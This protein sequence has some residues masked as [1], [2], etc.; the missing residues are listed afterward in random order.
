[1]ASDLHQ[2]A[3]S[4]AYTETDGFVSD[5]KQA[6]SGNRKYLT[7]R[8]LTRVGVDAVYFG[9]ETPLVYFRALDRTTFD[10]REI[11]ELHRRVWNDA[12]VPVLIV[13]TRRELRVYDACALPHVEDESA[14]PD[15]RL[16]VALE[17]T[18]QALADHR[19]RPFTRHQIE[20]GATWATYATRF[21]NE[22]RCDR[23]LLKNLEVTRDRLLDAD[24]PAEVVHELLPRIILILYLEHR[25]VLTSKFYGEF[26]SGAERLVDVLVSPSRT[27]RMFDALAEH[28]NGDLLPVGSE[29][30]RR[31]KA[32]HLDLLG[33]LL[34]GTERFDTGQRAF[35]PL[36]DFNVIPTELISSIYEMFLRSD[37]GTDAKGLH[38]TPP[39]L[40]EML[41]NEVLPW[42]DAKPS[43]DWRP[44]RIVDPACGSGIFLVEAYRRIVETVRLQRDLHDKVPVDVLRE[45]LSSCIFGVDEVKASVNVAACSLYLAMLDYIQPKAI[46]AQVRF[47]TL[48][49][50]P[51]G[52]R[53]NLIASDAFEPGAFEKHET[54]DLI[55]G[56]PPWKRN[57]LPE[58]AA[59][60]CRDRER[61]AAREIAHAFLW[62][63]T[64]LAGTSGKVAMFATSKWLF[65]REGPD[66]DFREAFFAQNRVDMV[67]NFSALRRSLF[68]A[69]TGP[70]SAVIFSPRSA[71]E[72]EVSNEILYGAPQAR[73]AGPIASALLTDAS[74]WKFVPSAYATAPAIWKVLTRGTWRDYQLYSKLRGHGPT[75]RQFIKERSGWSKGN[76]F[77]PFDPARNKAATNTFKDERL[78]RMPHIVAGKLAPYVVAPNAIQPRL[79][80]N[81][82]F[83]RR[84]HEA[85]YGAKPKVLVKEG[86]SNGKFCA[87]FFDRECTFTETI[88]GITGPE[89]DRHLLQ[90]LAVYLNSAVAT[91]FTFLNST[92][93]GIEREKVNAVEWLELPSD[94][95]ANET[96]AREL[97]A[98]YDE[99]AASEGSFDALRANADL[100]IM[101]ALEL[102]PG[103]KRLVF[104]FVDVCLPIVQRRSKPVEPASEPLLR[105]YLESCATQLSKATTSLSGTAWLGASP[106]VVAEFRPGRGTE[107]RKGDATIRDLLARLDAF[108]IEQESESVFL[109][110]HARISIGESVY[111]VKPADADL[112]TASAGMSDADE[113]LGD[114]LAHGAE[115]AASAGEAISR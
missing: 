42:P 113:I 20:S 52:R 114:L 69:A 59:A 36:Y 8:A 50:A 55:A 94:V 26:K 110:R 29:E 48:T 21:R 3:A 95:L 75:L 108:L 103:E 6:G 28:F 27:Y 78:E 76:G 33:R 61:P 49:T 16:I 35:W 98:I 80:K 37:D 38:Y 73:R 32:G 88:T 24:L 71:S 93:W 47:P 83:R 66:R 84:G 40:V 2:L 51:R 18:T 68:S 104:D 85:A 23:T 106:L 10:E 107:V 7:E 14:G 60:Y 87:V 97:V 22:S 12:R 89:R 19:L 53:P 72:D 115:R 81:V 77:Q 79:G 13:S 96:T 74:E 4:L 17:R 64:D 67:M 34:D 91:Y 54:F 43:R 56:N 11:A 31:V 15:E 39:A 86:Q 102:R 63:A 82:T 25:G 46:W 5:A 112:W 62:L 105:A 30:R 92:S 65:N 58:T 44:P 111:V 90:A 99:I 9:G 101:N 45:L 1:M 41:L 100:T 70:A 57:Y 109:R